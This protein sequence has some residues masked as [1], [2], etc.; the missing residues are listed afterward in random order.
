M[1]PRFAYW[2]ILVDDEPTAFRAKEAEELLPTLNRLKQK[3]PSAV[4]MWFQAGKLWRSRLE[5][6]DA[7]VAARREEAQK[8]RPAGDGPPRDRKW[9]PGGTHADPRQKFKDA[10]K[11]KWTRYKERVRQGERPRPPGKVA[12]PATTRRRREDKE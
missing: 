7:F 4:M 3:H 9:R 12:R 10:R 5:A 2:T 1:P 11:A 6:Q 8:K